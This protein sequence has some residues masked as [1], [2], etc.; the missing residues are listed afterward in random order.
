MSL[1][2]E[3]QREIESNVI[4]SLR[5]IVMVILSAGMLG[6]AM[7]KLVGVPQLIDSFSNWGI[8]R[9]IAFGI[10]VIELIIAIA[11]F[12]TESRKYAL[13]ALAILLFGAI[14]T[15]LYHQDIAG[16]IG[17]VAVLIGG[18]VLWWLDNLVQD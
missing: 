3:S 10:G 1:N 12:I 7:V 6:M 14:A 5:N 18:A 8:S 2:R 9:E 11:I 16:A 15:H 4:T 13:I 17:P